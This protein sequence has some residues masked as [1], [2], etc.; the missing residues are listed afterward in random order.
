MALDRQQQLQIATT[1]WRGGEPPTT[2]MEHGWR[3]YNDNYKMMTITTTGDDGRAGLTELQLQPEPEPACARNSHDPDD[4]HWKL[5]VV[6][7]RVFQ[8]PGANRGQNAGNS[9]KQPTNWSSSLFRRRQMCF[10]LVGGR[11]LYPYPQSG[12]SALDPGYVLG[13]VTGPGIRVGATDG[14]NVQHPALDQ[15]PELPPKLAKKSK[16]EFEKFFT[17]SIVWRGILKMVYLDLW[18]S[19]LQNLKFIFLDFKVLLDN[20]GK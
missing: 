4:W 16:I 13:F 14:N 17:A 3:A 18:T 1:R 9:P 11:A 12:F 20:L 10:R 5:V 7:G 8:G 15:I 2:G 19:L 6:A